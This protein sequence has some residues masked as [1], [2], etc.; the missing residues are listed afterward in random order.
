MYEKNKKGPFG[1]VGSF[2]R[3]TRFIFVAENLVKEEI[4]CACFVHGL[5]SHKL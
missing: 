4:L 3:A 1:L 5:A 2:S